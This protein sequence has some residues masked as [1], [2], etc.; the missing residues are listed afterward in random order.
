MRPITAFLFQHV[1]R[2]GIRHAPC[3][4][5]DPPSWPS[6]TSQLP[7]SVH[8]STPED[9]CDDGNDDDGGHALSGCSRYQNTIRVGGSRE[10]DPP[11]HVLVAD[12]PPSLG[13]GDLGPSPYDLLLGSLGSCTSI[14][15]SMY[16]KQKEWPLEGV[17]VTLD[18]EKVYQD[19]CEEC[20]A[21][22]EE[23]TDEENAKGGGKQGAQKIDHISR[24]V[25]LRGDDLTEK[26]IARLQKV[27]DMCPVHR[28]LEGSG[29]CITTTWAER[30]PPPPT[31]GEDE[32][33]ATTAMKMMTVQKFAGRPHELSTGFEVRRVLPY[34]KC[35]SVGS[36]VFLDHF[37][38]ADVTALGTM[39][40]APHPHI[41]LCTLTY[42]YDGAILH[43]DST[44]T[45]QHILPGQVNW[46]VAGKGVVHTE[47]GKEVLG[48]IPSRDRGQKWMHGL[49][50]WAALP[51]EREDV[52]PKLYHAE[53]AVDV[54]GF[55]EGCRVK[56]VVGTA[57]GVVQPDVELEEGTGDLFLVDAMLSEKGST[58][59]LERLLDSSS[60]RS[61]GGGGIEVGIYVT[62]GS[63]SCLGLSGEGISLSVGEMA[64]F[65]A[66]GGGGGGSDETRI[67]IPSGA[68]L[69]ALEPGTRLAILGGTPLKEKRHMYWNFVSHSREKVAEAARLWSELDRDKF[70]PVPGESNEDSIL[71]HALPSRRPS[72]SSPSPKY[73]GTPAVS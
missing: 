71:L 15:L 45:Q 34:H 61:S 2:Q 64:V 53:G 26:Q 27:A 32:E 57:F 41:G 40:V 43:R 17:D 7:F 37:G 21:A 13:G 25:T 20:C 52:D 72:S 19:D 60:S 11:R 55:D 63:V 5:P 30:L 66:R 59:P 58:L 35:R 48:L 38:P 39:D 47:R 42:L 29:V 36:F 49:Q 31:N 62:S 73:G 12:E 24:T 70:P 23:G 56:V 4:T 67:I 28:T 8:I 22:G 10:G 14:T 9:P 18:H 68:S 65:A 51:R 44:G 69:R 16:A 3:R 46:M 6:S 54:P 1:L 50:L 33:E